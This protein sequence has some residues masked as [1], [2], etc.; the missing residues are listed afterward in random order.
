MRSRRPFG[1][2]SERRA[3]LSHAGK[4]KLAGDRD[5]L[6]PLLHL[7]IELH[8]PD[9]NERRQSS[10]AAARPRESLGDDS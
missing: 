5:E 6:N 7:V 8:A 2:R 4:V 3:Q 10:R 1:R 9:P